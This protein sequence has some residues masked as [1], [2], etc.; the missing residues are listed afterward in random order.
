MPY[1]INS[2]AGTMI[3]PHLRNTFTHSLTIPAMSH[4]QSL[5]SCLN[6]RTP[7]DIFQTVDPFGKMCSFADLNHIRI[8]A[9]WIRIVNENLLKLML[10]NDENECQVLK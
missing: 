10:P 1:I 9:Y 6:A 3:N 5:N 2:I 4:G 8:V 7:L